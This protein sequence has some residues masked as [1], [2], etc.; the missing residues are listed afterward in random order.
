MLLS[1]VIPA[2]AGI[3]T[4]DPAWFAALVMTLPPVMV[5]RFHNWQ[6]ILFGS[7]V[8][9]LAN[10]ILALM[11]KVIRQR[12]VM[13]LIGKLRPGWQERSTRV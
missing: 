6:E 12:V 2:G 10:V 9:Y 13:P 4:S 3:L 5:L 8:L 7:G 1:L 11:G